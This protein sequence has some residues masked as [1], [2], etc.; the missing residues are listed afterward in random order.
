MSN[1]R[2]ATESDATEIIFVQ[3]TTWM[4][5]YP[6]IEN[7]ISEDDIKSID[8]Q[9]KILSWQHMIKS[10]DYEVVVAAKGENILAFCVVEKRA[11]PVLESLY[12]LPLHQEGGIGT[13][14]LTRCMDEYSQLWL[15]VASYNQRAIH[16]Y[17]K[18]GFEL[19]GARGSHSLPSGAHIPTLE[20][21][22]RKS[23]QNRSMQ[24]RVGRSELARLSKERPSTIKWYSEVGLLPFAQEEGRMRRHYYVEPALRRL[25]EIR[26]LKE[27]GYS[28]DEIKKRL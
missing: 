7:G 6:S 15:E 19:T 27:R 5:S 21:R 26:K 10:P 12:V 14:L 13:Q 20:M 22:Y 11:N 4:D 28:L 9:G 3:A 1:L 24:K 18:H 8:W 17:E 16:F 25:K 2:H 23:P